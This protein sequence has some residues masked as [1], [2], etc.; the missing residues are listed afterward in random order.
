MPATKS[1]LIPHVT[2][3]PS[4]APRCAREARAHP[5]GQPYPTPGPASLACV[6]NTLGRN[7]SIPATLE[8]MSSLFARYLK[9]P[10]VQGAIRHESPYSRGLAARRFRVAWRYRKKRRS[11]AD[12]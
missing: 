3:R 2:T 12:V 5:R 6:Y 4:G 9:G 1:A 8:E 11:R 7:T 10:R